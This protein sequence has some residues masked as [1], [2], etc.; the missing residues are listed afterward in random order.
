[1]ASKALADKF[2]SKAPSKFEEEDEPEMAESPRGAGAGAASEGDD[3][4]DEMMDSPGA[5]AP[6]GGPDKGPASS[7][8]DDM[9]DILG[10]GPEDRMDFQAA[11]QAAVMEAMS[12][13]M[14]GGP[15]MGAP[16]GPMQANDLDMGDSSGTMSRKGY[17]GQGTPRP[18]PP[19]DGGKPGPK[20]YLLG[21]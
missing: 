13:M 2:K 7:P 8:M 9:A 5:G 20:K 1:M 21:R 12:S 14:G 17:G 15:D 18:D 3:D 11:F 19:G 16:P 10:V 4:G 6:S